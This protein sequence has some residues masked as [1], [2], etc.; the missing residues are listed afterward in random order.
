MTGEETVGTWPSEAEPG[1]AAEA[2]ICW[3]LDSL[4]TYPDESWIWQLGFREYSDLLLVKCSGS[5][6]ASFCGV[7]L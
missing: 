2:G 5:A 1:G 4:S 7:Y 3:D 6:P